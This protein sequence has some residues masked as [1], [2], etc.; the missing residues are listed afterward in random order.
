ML[1]PV[2][3]A[4][5]RCVDAIAIGMLAVATA[6]QRC[7]DARLWR[8]STS[9]RGARADSPRGGAGAAV[10]CGDAT[11]LQRPAGRWIWEPTAPGAPRRVTQVAPG[12][13]ACRGYGRVRRPGESALRIAIAAV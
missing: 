8:A 11:R 6:N 9:R 10:R 1:E 13:R 12:G 4:I 2:L 3:V 7:S 5:H